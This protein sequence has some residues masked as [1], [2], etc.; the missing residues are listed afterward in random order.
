MIT[1]LILL[2]AVYTMWMYDLWRVKRGRFAKC[3]GAVVLMSGG[4][5]KHVIHVRNVIN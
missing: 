5:S 1:H 3:G 2:S 4:E